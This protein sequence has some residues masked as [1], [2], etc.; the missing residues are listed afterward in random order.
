[1]SRPPS[2][3]QA[4]LA[5]LG[6]AQK[7]DLEAVARALADRQAALDR[8]ETPTPGVLSAGELTATLLREFVRDARLEDLR[9][10]RLASDFG[11]SAH[12][13]ISVRG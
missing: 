3:E 5:A 13:S 2:L 12:P 6:A 1:M 8:G 4:S 11:G 7:G 9:L 10:R